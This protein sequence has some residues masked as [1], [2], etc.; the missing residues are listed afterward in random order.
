MK[1]F[2][3]IIVCIHLTTTLFAEIPSFYNMK[4]Q[5]N[6]PEEIIQKKQ[7]KLISVNKSKKVKDEISKKSIK[8]DKTILIKNFNFKGNIV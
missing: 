4:N 5:Y 6:I 8:N 2:Y 3:R 1:Q 7:K